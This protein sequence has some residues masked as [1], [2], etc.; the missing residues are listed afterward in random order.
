MNR[1]LDSIAAFMVECSQHSGEMTCG[2]SSPGTP[3]SW[4]HGRLCV[5]G[6]GEYRCPQARV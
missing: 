1:A 2:S 6:G 3:D 5:C 4:T